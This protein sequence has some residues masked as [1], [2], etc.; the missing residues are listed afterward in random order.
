MT[1]LVLIRMRMCQAM[2]TWTCE[3]TQKSPRKLSGGFAA[4]WPPTPRIV[5]GS[6]LSP[7]QL[8]VGAKIPSC[9][10]TFTA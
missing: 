6:S 8:R 7:E 5:D 10:P 2:F 1:R 4:P 9:H 3:N